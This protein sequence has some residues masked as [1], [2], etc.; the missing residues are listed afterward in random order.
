LDRPALLYR[1]PVLKVEI[2]GARSFFAAV[3]E[4][5]SRLEL[6]ELARDHLSLLERGEVEVAAEKPA[7]LYDLLGNRLPS[8]AELRFAWFG[9]ELKEPKPER[10][11]PVRFKITLRDGA[12]RRR[13]TLRV[14]TAMEAFTV[15]ALVAFDL[16]RR[17]RRAFPR[18]VAGG[19]WAPAMVAPLGHPFHNFNTLKGM[20]A[21]P[22]ARF[23]ARAPRRGDADLRSSLA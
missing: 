1:A 5:S 9:F 22:P 12:W 2:A 6:Y 15:E 17:E 14:E 23:K 21:Q 7:R 4:V 18:A 8:K 20:P 13:R 19:R 16:A 3:G 10:R 11:V